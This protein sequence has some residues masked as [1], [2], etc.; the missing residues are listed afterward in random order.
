MKRTAIRVDDIT[1]IA[2]S[3][4]ATLT[5]QQSI[6][7]RDEQGHPSLRYVHGFEPGG[8]MCL[9]DI[10]ASPIPYRFFYHRDRIYD[11]VLIL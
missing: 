1:V 3:N 10:L 5:D 8:S 9:D 11:P 4:N 6:S 2:L 7:L